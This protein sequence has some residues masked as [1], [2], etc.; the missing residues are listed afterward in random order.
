MEYCKC[1]KE[2][3]REKIFEYVLYKVS[4]C[5]QNIH[6]ELPDI[7]NDVLYALY[8]ERWGRFIDYKDISVNDFLE[9]LDHSTENIEDET[10]KGKAIIRHFGLDKL[11]SR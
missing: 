4:S 3:T 5:K 11:L 8:C 10:V 2:H 1:K 6:V 9:W 7:Y